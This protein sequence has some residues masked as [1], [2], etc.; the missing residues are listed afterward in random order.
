MGC[1][2][3]E[4]YEADRSDTEH[5]LEQ[6]SLLAN[7]ALPLVRQCRSGLSAAIAWLEHCNRGRHH[8]TAAKD[9]DS[10]QNICS[11]LQHALAEFDTARLVAI[12]PYRHVFDPAHP[13]ADDS[14]HRRL[15]HRGLF[16]VFV[17]HYHLMEFS[18]ALLRLLH[19]LADFDTA[20]PHRKFWY[21]RVWAL[22]THMRSS[23]TE[24]HL[25][26]GDD[27]QE[28]DGDFARHDEDDDELG[29]ANKRNPEYVPF[30]NP[31][32]NILS[33]L[34]SLPNV[35]RSRGFS[36]AVKAGVLTALT[37]LPQFIASSAAFYYYNR[38]I[39]CAIMAQLTLAMYSGDTTAAWLGRCVA[40]FWGAVFGMAVW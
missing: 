10:M 22:V 5:I 15:K 18:E 4:Q 1:S 29:E 17:A 16:Q 27:E 31:I 21:P 34:A 11:S 30:E 9:A 6:L 40:S 32:L 25:T 20:R 12:K 19:M 8:G 37:T 7:A 36:F 23:H 14:D 2:S 38:G 35:L 26:D 39:W 28:D 33:R 13:P 3:F 24:M